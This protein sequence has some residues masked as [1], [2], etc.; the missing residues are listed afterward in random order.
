MTPRRKTR[1]EHWFS[2]SRHRR[3]A[4]AAALAQSLGGRDLQQLK[5]T[6]V[7]G[8]PGEQAQ[9]QH[10]SLIDLRAHLDRLRL[11]FIG[12]PELL[13]HHA[14]LIVMIRREAQVREN[15]ALLR[16]L[17]LTETQ[18]LCASLDMRWLVA[19]CDTFVDH[20]A[21]PVVRATLMNGVL[22]VNTIKLQETERFLAGDT[23]PVEDPHASAALHAG[24]VAL[25]DGLAAFVEG[26]D[27]TLR[28]MRWR[29]DEVCGLHPLGA[30]V[31]EI[32]KR[33]QQAQNDNVYLRFRQRHTR[34]RTAWW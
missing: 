6:L 33:L 7:Q 27:D 23:Q 2:L 10:G 34:E 21:D 18:F 3:R 29:L 25:F 17:W 12:Q 24:R 1:F 30:I 9:Y 8:A 5:N 26:V 14:A 28:N 4:G 15:F 32:F 13:Y 11:E 16:E 20:D 22:L 31:L 19:A